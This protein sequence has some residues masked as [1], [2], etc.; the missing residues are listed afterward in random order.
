MDSTLV[1]V[2][3]MK[4][5]YFVFGTNNMPAAVAFYDALFDGMGVQRHPDDGRMTLWIGDGFLFALAEPFDEQL[6]TVGNGSMCG[7]QFDNTDQII[8]R[9]TLAIQLGGS[10]EGEPRIRSDRFSAYVRDLDGNKLCFFN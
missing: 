10:D 3:T 4:M 8:E 5:S 9:H 2:T 6:A 1:Q 7:F